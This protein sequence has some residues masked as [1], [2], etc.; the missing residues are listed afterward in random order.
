MTQCWVKERL[1]YEARALTS[2]LLL[3]TESINGNNKGVLEEWGCKSAINNGS[4]IISTKKLS[5]L[6]PP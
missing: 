5:S 2:S 6:M 1:S 3:D 4:V